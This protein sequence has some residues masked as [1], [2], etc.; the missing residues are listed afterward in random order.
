MTNLTTP[1]I[2][3]DDVN[4]PDDEQSL[5]ARIPLLAGSSK[6]MAYL[7]FRATGFSVG[8]ACE[9]ADCTRQTVQNWRKSDAVF[10]DI[11]QNRLGDLQSTVGNDVIK[12]DFLRNMK[13]LLHADMQLIAKAMSEGLDELSSR[14]FEVYKNVRKFY[15]PSDW[16]ALEKVLA[17]EKHQEVRPINITLSWGN[18]IDP[19]MLVEGEAKE[20]PDEPEGQFRITTPA[21]DNSDLLRV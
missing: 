15:T 2:D 17:P 20:V 12:F 13:Y 1:D 3:F 11:E 8:K 18:R 9:L 19:N 4:L 21:D 14:E 10:A 5:L 7:A 6:K 16:L